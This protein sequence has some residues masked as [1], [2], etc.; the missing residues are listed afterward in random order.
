M[1]YVTPEQERYFRKHYAE[2]EAAMLYI[3]EQSE[4]YA[5]QYAP[6]AL[7]SIKAGIARLFFRYCIEHDKGEK[8]LIR[9]AIDALLEL[10]RGL[11]CNRP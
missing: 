3:I 11:A 2:P 1:N 8:A 6:N 10:A 4:A 7:P 5:Q 9:S